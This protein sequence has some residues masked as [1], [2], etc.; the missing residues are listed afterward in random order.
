MTRPLVATALVFATGCFEIRAD[1]APDTGAPPSS[2]GPVDAGVP[3]DAWLPSVDAAAPDLGSSAPDAAPQIDASVRDATAPTDSGVV[4][5]GPPACPYLLCEDFEAPLD[6]NVWS[7]EMPYH[8]ATTQI[9]VISSSAAHGLHALHVRSLSPDAAFLKETVTQTGTLTQHLFGRAYLSISM[10][11]PSHARIFVGG[12]M[13][14]TEDGDQLE[15]GGYG[16]GWQ[17]TFWSSTKGEHP[18]AGGTIPTQTW[19]CIQFELDNASG[20]IQVGGPGVR[21]FQMSGASNAGWATAGMQAVY[22]G[23]EGPT[24]VDLYLDDLAIDSKPVP[25]LP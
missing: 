25:C 2:P 17:L 1:V 3:N 4:D 20:L 8:P 21:G 5:S 15:V 22:F 6:M 16:G 12:P 13:T 10:A 23:Y 18:A 7:F 14:R 19:T 11:P 24:P 9:E